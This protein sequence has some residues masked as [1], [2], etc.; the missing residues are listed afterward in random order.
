V[1]IDKKLQ[2]D[3]LKSIIVSIGEPAGIGPDIIVNAWVNRKSLDL[4]HFTVIGDLQILEKRAQLLGMEL[5]LCVVKNGAQAIDCHEYLPII[6]LANAMIDAGPIADT[7][8]AAGVIEAIERGVELVLADEFCALTTCPINKK[9]LYDSGFE[10]PGHTEYL[11]SLSEKRSGETLRPVMMLAGPK[12]RSVPVTIHV[13]LA[14]VPEALSLDLILDISRITAK[15]LRKN[16]RISDPVLAITGLNPHAGEEGAMGREEIEIIAPAVE[17]LQNEGIRAIGP[18][19]ADTMFHESARKAYDVAICMY[20]DQ[21][22]IPAKAL[23]FD[24]AVNVTLG[25]PFIRTSPDHGT[26]CNI[27]GSGKARPDSF[28][29]ALKMAADMA[30]NHAQASEG[31]S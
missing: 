16:F 2:P 19:P 3:S 1:S 13:A 10:F 8:N 27:A 23:G 7:A 17:I 31:A 22:L 15:G 9:S 21:A 4:P 29:A 14:L 5:P 18:L 28:V 6:E 26:A 20:H 30:S 24:D 25:L 12:L 11:A